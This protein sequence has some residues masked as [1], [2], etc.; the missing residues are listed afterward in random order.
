MGVKIRGLA[1]VLLAGL[2]LSLPA[3]YDCDHFAKWLFATAFVHSLAWSVVILWLIHCHQRLVASF[4]TV[5]YLLFFLET[6]SYLVVGARINETVMTIVMQTNF[7]EAWEFARNYLISWRALG[8]LIVACVLYVVMIRWVTGTQLDRL[9]KTR[10]Q[11]VL[12]FVVALGG[13]VFPLIPLSWTNH[14]YNT[15]AG[16]YHSVQ[17]VEESHSDVDRIVTLMD[18]IRVVQQP[19]TSEAPVIVLVIGESFNKYHSP[20]YG[21]PLQ[22]TPRLCAE[23]RLVV[24]DQASSPVCFTHSAM[25][26]IMSLKSCDNH[27]A[28]DP[29]QHVLLPAVFK[30][31]GYRVG[32]F[33]NQFTRVKVGFNDYSCGYFYSPQRISDRCFDL[34]NDLIDKY[35]G[36]FIE[37]YRDL[38]L[39][40]PKSL[41][42]IHLFGQHLK[43]KIRYP[44]SFSYFK[45]SDIPREDL[46][47]QER[48]IVAEYDNATRY[49]D[50]VVGMIL[51]AF[52][53]QDA[54]VV[55]L[56]DH[57]DNI[58]DGPGHRYGRT[59]GG[60]TDE[61]SKKNIREIPFLVWCSETFL[62]K[63]PEVY[64]RLC[65]RAHQPVCLDDVAHL[66]F[67]LG[68]ITCNFSTPS[69]SL[70][71]PTYLPHLTAI[72]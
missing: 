9:F 63:R 61:E 33:D 11:R 20:L 13:L 22:T 53:E 10:L 46:D 19:E 32:Y 12:A 45:G 3:G 8:V 15:V 64:E 71:S 31:A 62:Q 68:G 52:R 25:R 49:H 34:R 35:D 56:S 42:I 21:Y 27:Q 72:E 5:I 58:Y 54:V 26:Y 57:G 30:Q 59:A 40:E 70:L 24:F 51:D 41:N 50:M 29:L 4:F 38:F 7:Q 60:L 6:A 1:V 47:E 48:E 66:L 39:K 65:L 37:R 28:D 2:L 14:G 36:T 23:K 18:S 69:R 67:D 17:F 44:E 16:L 43:A 55:Y